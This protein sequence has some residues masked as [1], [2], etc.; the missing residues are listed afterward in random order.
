MWASR[1]TRPPTRQPRKPL[2]GEKTAA[3]SSQQTH[4]P[5]YNHSE[6]RSA[7]GAR[8]KQSDN[9]S[10]HGE[11]TRKVAR[12]TDTRQ[13]PLRRCCNSTRG[14]ANVRARC[15]CSYEPRRLDSMTSS[16][17]NTFPP[18]QAPAAAAERGDR[19][20]S[21]FSSAAASTRTS[22]I[23]FSPTFPDDTASGPS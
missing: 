10:V 23:A 16:S 20:S 22:G 18:S 6:R 21:T 8:S 4:L 17:I 13:R 5:S 14:S 7:D 19:P 11:K 15:W 3:A 9:G 2:D 1:E 12:H